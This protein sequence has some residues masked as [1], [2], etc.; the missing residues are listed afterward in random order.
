MNRKL[1]VRMS[2]T[3]YF[4]FLLSLS[5]ALTQLRERPVI[6]DTCTGGNQFPSRFLAHATISKR[7]FAGVQ[8]KISHS[9]GN[10][11][12]IERKPMNSKHMK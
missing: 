9:V 10:V 11:I 1:L 12:S 2:Y 6:S 8:N 7:A 5:D 4:Q 3:H